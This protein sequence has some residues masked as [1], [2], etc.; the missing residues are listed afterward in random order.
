MSCDAGLKVKDKIKVCVGGTFDILHKGHVLLLDKAFEIGDIVYIGL[1]SDDILKSKNDIQPFHE[2]KQK[3]E[4]YLSKYKKDYE[5][6]EITDRYGTAIFE[7]YD[8]IVVSDET[9]PV[10]ISINRIRTKH[11]LN[12]L[13]IVNVGTVF[14]EDLIPIKSSRIRTREIDEYGTRL[15][16]LLLCIGSTNPTKIAGVRNIFKKVVKSKIRFLS[17]ATDSQVPRQPF[18]LDT[19]RG[20]INRALTAVKNADLGIGIESGLFWNSI[21]NKYF[22]VQYCAIADKTGHITLGIGPGF[23]YPKEVI[24]HVRTGKTVTEAME[25]IYKIHDIGKDIGAVG[26]LSKKLVTRTELTEHCV[27]MAVIPRLRS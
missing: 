5:V 9:E 23:A 11:R 24:E 21:V 1:T 6:I 13:Q 4:H 22:D 7:N 25:L 10:A 27:M 17:I 12:P 26:Y 15:T 14:G 19:I 18:E 2:R 20:A 16:E 3:L 8:V